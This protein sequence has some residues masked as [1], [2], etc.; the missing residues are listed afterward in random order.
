[1]TFRRGDRVCHAQHRT[2]TGTVA[3]P[4]HANG[5]V[6]VT[7]DH[8]LRGVGSASWVREDDLLWLPADTPR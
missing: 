2:L 5:E 7:W 1:M 4:P 3:G 8:T 6:F